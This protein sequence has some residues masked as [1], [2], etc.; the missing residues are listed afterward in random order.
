MLRRVSFHVHITELE[1]R[2]Q[3]LLPRSVY[4]Y[5]VNPLVG[6]AYEHAI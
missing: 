3:Y 5:F 2:M 4:N 6:E 1:G